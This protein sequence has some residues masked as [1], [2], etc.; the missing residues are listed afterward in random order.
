M[1][2]ETQYKTPQVCS[3]F[4]NSKIL[5]WANIQNLSKS[6]RELSIIISFCLLVIDCYKVLISQTMCCMNIH[7]KPA[8]NRGRQCW[9]ECSKPWFEC[10][11]AKWFYHACNSNISQK[12]HIH[13]NSRY[14]RKYKY[15]K[16][17]INI[18]NLK[19]NY[20]KV[21]FQYT[22]TKSQVWL[23]ASDLTFQKA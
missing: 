21:E 3:G 13:S 19:N 8:H 9:T 6:R 20:F 16:T 14:E 4:W 15:M 17:T 2:N 5:W 23:W 18:L 1:Q 11:G 22:K 12:S 10:D 7:Y